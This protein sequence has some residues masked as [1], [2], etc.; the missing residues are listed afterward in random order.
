MA[1][2]LNGNASGGLS[3]LNSSTDKETAQGYYLKAVASA[4]MDKIGDVT[5][6]L[7]K[8]IA[9]DSAYKAKAKKDREF[10]KYTENSA[11]QAL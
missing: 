10:L 6:N 9:M 7:T 11:F 3:T 8:A 2:I 4:R 1:Q 5:S